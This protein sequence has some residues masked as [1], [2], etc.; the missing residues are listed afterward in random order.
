MRINK[1]VITIIG[2]IFILSTITGC[3]LAEDANENKPFDNFVSTVLDD[4]NELDKFETGDSKLQ[5]GLAKHEEEGEELKE[6]I[7]EN[8]DRPG[9]FSKLG[10]FIL[11]FILN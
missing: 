8:D 1:K 9:F 10:H 4:E 2:S 6:Y 7:Q 5:Q 3:T 11:D